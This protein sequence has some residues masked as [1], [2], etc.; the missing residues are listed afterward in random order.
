MKL[1]RFRKQTAPP[2]EITCRELVRLV[3]NYLEGALSKTD[4]D[5]FDAHLAKCDGCTAYLAQVRDTI[6]IT[7]TLTEESLALE[8]RDELLAAFR[9]WKHERQ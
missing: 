3:T 2:D 9:T 6:R 4:V 8:G 5:R 7:G 1:P